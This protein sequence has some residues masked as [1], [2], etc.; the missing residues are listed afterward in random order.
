MSA[1][2]TDVYELHYWP[3]IQGRGEFIRLALEFAEVPYIDVA[4]RPV[5]EG[6]GERALYESLDDAHPHT[7]P[8]APPY[9]RTPELVVGQ[10]ANI[11]LF[12][13]KHHALAPDYEA[14]WLWTA[15]VAADD[16]RSDRRSARYTSSHQRRRVLRGSETRSTPAQ[17]HFLSSA[18]RSTSG[19]SRRSSS[20]IGPVRPGWSATRSRMRTCRC[21]RSSKVCATHSRAGRRSTNANTR[22]CV[23]CTMRSRDFRRLPL[24]SLHR[25]AFLS[26]RK[27]SFRHYEE[28]DSAD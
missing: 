28:L 8:F 3:T 5:K 15:S 6:G 20:A 12:L 25:V 2:R 18:C 11:L 7:I 23:R 10:T 1:T 27:A 13:G 9:L 24:T 26:T 17:R 4:R 22:A 21:F 16:R 14:G 19:I